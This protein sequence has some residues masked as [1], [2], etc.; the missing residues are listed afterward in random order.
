MYELA[1]TWPVKHPRPNVSIC[2]LHDVVLEDD[3]CGLFWGTGYE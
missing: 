2:K 1:G 3:E